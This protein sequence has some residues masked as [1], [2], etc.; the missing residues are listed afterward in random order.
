MVCYSKA[1]LSLC[2]SLYA[3]PCLR[4]CLRLCLYVWLSFIREE[5]LH[6]N[7]IHL[8]FLFSLFFFF[9]FFSR[10][11]FSLLLS[12]FSRL[13]DPGTPS[14]PHFQGGSSRVSSTTT[15]KRW[16]TR[17]VW[18]L[19]TEWPPILFFFFLYYYY[20]GSSQNI[21]VCVFVCLS[22]S[23][24]I[25]PSVRLS[26]VYPFYCLYFFLF[27]LSFFLSFKNFCFVC[28]SL[29]FLIRGVYLLC[30]LHELLFTLVSFHRH[31]IPCHLRPRKKSSLLCTFQLSNIIKRKTN[32]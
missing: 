32:F 21:G 6:S 25:Y 7:A 19:G 17:K 2:L 16:S 28:W 30:S 13:S 18:S 27:L 20:S 15:E 14:K 12:L 26:V 31:H 11:S 29:G 9:F 10:H 3:P 5:G 1:L 22:V 8:L 24:S 4:L 23:A